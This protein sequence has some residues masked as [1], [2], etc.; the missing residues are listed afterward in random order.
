MHLN[1]KL[2]TALTMCVSFAVITP[3]NKI[4]KKFSDCQNIVLKL[5]L[6]LVWTKA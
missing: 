5:F 1:G 6:E 2:S 3:V 4:L